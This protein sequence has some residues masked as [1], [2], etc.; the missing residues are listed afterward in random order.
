MRRRRRVLGPGRHCGPGT[1]PCRG[2]RAPR[3][4]TE[5]H[6]RAWKH[7]TIRVHRGSPPPSI[8]QAGADPA[9]LPVLVKVAGTFAWTQGAVTHAGWFEW[10]S[11]LPLEMRSTLPDGTEVL[12]VHAAPGRDDGIGFYP[13]LTA[14]ELAHLLG[15]CDADLVFAGHTHQQVDVTVRGTRIVNVGSVSN[16]V[17]P[18]L[19]ASYVLLEAG[20]SGYSLEHRQVEYNRQAV[21]EALQRLL[22]PGAGFI[23]EHMRGLRRPSC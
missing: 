8:E 16:P 14:P 10:L 7:R 12:G 4:I 3:G 5:R 6:M 11:Q 9:L 2:D 23:V 13:G 19:R 17:P 20:G 18:D 22:H 1:R 21:V 15:D